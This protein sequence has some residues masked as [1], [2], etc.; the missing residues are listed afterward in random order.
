MAYTRPHEDSM[1][2]SVAALFLPSS[3]HLGRLAAQA[4]V[5]AAS[6]ARLA[7]PDRDIQPLDLGHQPL[8]SVY[9]PGTFHPDLCLSRDD[10]PALAALIEVK[11]GANVNATLQSTC[12]GLSP[13][14]GDLAARIR[15]HYAENPHWYSESARKGQPGRPGV[16]QFD[17]YVSWQWWDRLVDHNGRAVYP[18]EGTQHVL[19]TLSGEPLAESVDVEGV[20]SQPFVLSQD[21]WIPVKLHEMLATLFELAQEEGS[22]L[23][24]RD[25]ILVHSAVTRGYEFDEETEAKHPFDWVQRG[26]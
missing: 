6:Q 11:G 1:T 2:R 20:G 7:H 22:K 25:R 10:T 21:I 23:A 12:A 3:P 8:S 17:A 16:A 26:D 24:E 4:M 19:L 18:D 9:P 15:H 14:P 13:A 5:A